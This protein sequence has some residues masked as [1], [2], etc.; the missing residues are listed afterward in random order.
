MDATRKTSKK[1]GEYFTYEL[2][3]TINAPE[4]CKLPNRKLLGRSYKLG[5]AY[6]LD[7][8]RDV[9]KA[10]APK[11]QP[12]PT[13]VEPVKNGVEIEPKQEESKIEFH[14]WCKSNGETYFDEADE[15]DWEKY[16]A[17]RERCNAFLSGENESAEMTNEALET[18]YEA[19][20]LVEL[21]D[22]DSNSTVNTEEIKRKQEVKRQAVLREKQNAEK[23]LKGRAV[24]ASLQDIV[25]LI[26]GD[27]DC[28][29]YE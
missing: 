27:E 1:Y 28:R 6:G 25:D 20:T 24:S 12:K 10:K 17:L 15:M 23:K 16:E 2:L 14:D 5:T 21:P 19:P 7:A 11:E 13:K 26:D 3:D 9:I 22:T 8:L 4:G 18:P 29:E